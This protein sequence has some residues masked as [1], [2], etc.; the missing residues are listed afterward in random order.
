[1]VGFQLADGGVENDCLQACSSIGAGTG[2]SGKANYVCMDNGSGQG[3]Y[4]PS[5]VAVSGQCSGTYATCVTTGTKAGFC[6]T[7]STGSSCEG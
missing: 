2:T 7:D 3:F 4:F 1:M 6:C 5:C